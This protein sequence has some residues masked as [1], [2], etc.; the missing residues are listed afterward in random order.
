M[1]AGRFR[2]SYILIGGGEDSG[3]FSDDEG[4]GDLLEGDIQTAIKIGVTSYLVVPYSNYIG[5]FDPQ[6]YNEKR[7]AFSHEQ[8]KRLAIKERAI[9]IE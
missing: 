9:K 6:V 7:Q 4:Y 2:K 3:D 8:A 5:S 1:K